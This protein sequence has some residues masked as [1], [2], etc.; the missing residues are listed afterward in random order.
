M[1]LNPERR[2]ETVKRLRTWPYVPPVPLIA[3]EQPKKPGDLVLTS[4][5]VQEIR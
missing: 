3:R 2:R 5:G 1:K 4:S